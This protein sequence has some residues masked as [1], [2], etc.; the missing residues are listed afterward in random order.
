[1]SRVVRLGVFIFAALLI[2]GAAVFLIGEKRFLFSPTY[3]LKA[4]FDNV[5]GLDE[6]APV[7]AGG[8]RIGTVEK[9]QLPSR[10]NE[11]VVIEMQLDDATQSVIRKDSVAAI[12]TEGL[13]GS[14]YLEISF[15][16]AQSESVRDGDIV[17]TRPPLDYADIA[18]KAGDTIESAKQA[19]VSAKDAIDMSKSA[20][21]NLTT[22]T[23]DV[24]SITSKI[25]SGEGTIGAF[26]ND[27]KT[28]DNINAMTG[29]LREVVDEAKTGVVSFQENMEALKHNFLLRG[30]FRDRGYFDSADLTRYAI[31]R[32][33]EG[34]PSKKFVITSKD[35]FD[36]PDNAKLDKEKLLNEVG[37]YLEGNDFGFAVIV[38][39]TG[40]QGTK[41]ENLKLS[42]ARAAVVRQYLAETFKIDDSRIRTL[43]LGESTQSEISKDGVLEVLIYSRDVV[44]RT[45]EAKAK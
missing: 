35:L 32:L 22:A 36:K 20:I 30:F 31:D 38:A 9:I 12:E 14:K 15:G 25:N 41:E 33:P 13:L 21:G 11:K 27:R 26:V 3:R 28:F 7:R 23:R 8:V 4:N 18:R 17:Q 6:G 42:Q 10:P 37:K 44:I 29:S 2:F 24:K 19:I 5:A 40:S 43:G 1:M 34:A 45:A 16:S 39:Y